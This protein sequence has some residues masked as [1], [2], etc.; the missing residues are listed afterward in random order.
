MAMWSEPPIAV[1]GDGG[2]TTTATAAAMSFATTTT[3]ASRCP[4]YLQ[5][6][7]CT[8]ASTDQVAS[9]ADRDSRIEEEVEALMAIFGEEKLSTHRLHDE[10]GRTS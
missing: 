9:D 3:P 2:T 8:H 1:L 4:E 6:M 7:R 10:L 5:P